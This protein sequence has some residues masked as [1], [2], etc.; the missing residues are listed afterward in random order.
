LLETLHWEFL[1]D[2]LSSEAAMI[3]CDKSKMPSRDRSRA[4][5]LDCLL[6]VDLHCDQVTSEAVVDSFSLFFFKASPYY[7]AFVDHHLLKVLGCSLTMVDPLSPIS[8]LLHRCDRLSRESF[9][10]AT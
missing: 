7:H 4:Y 10:D 1:L 2:L 9:Q 6:L 5:L 3:G 8:L